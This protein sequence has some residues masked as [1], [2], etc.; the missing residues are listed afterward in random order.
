MI[1][2]ASIFWSIIFGG[3]GMG[4]LLYARQQSNPF[5]F[6]S[7]VVLCVYPYFV[8]NI[9]MVLLIGAAVIALPFLLKV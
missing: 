4:Y 7:G 5:A 2:E 3:V 9:F 8:D 6:F 1:L